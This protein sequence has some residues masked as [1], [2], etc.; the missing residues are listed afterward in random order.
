MGTPPPISAIQPGSRDVDRLTLLR[1]E[2]GE[3]VFESVR[4]ARP[5]LLLVP[6]LLILSLLPWW[7][8]ASATP[9]R[10]IVSGA[11]ALLALLA[12][13]NGAPRRRRLLLR[14]TAGELLAGASRF[15]LG[16]APRWILSAQS[17]LSSPSSIYSAELELSSGERRILLKHSDPARL[18][19]QL[20]EALRCWPIPVQC[21][22][23][24]P[25]EAEPWRYESSAASTTPPREIG[26]SVVKNGAANAGLEWALVIMATLVVIDLIFL[27]SSEGALVAD[28]HPF[29]VALPLFAGGAIGLLAVGV[30]TLERRWVIGGEI[31]AQSRAFAR[32]RVHYAAPVTSI[33]GVF[34]VG[35]RDAEHCHVLVD[36]GTGPL[37]LEVTQA[38]ASDFLERTRAGIQAA[39]ARLAG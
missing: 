19:R 12:A 17:E 36:S 3:L 13:G 14:P 33:R 21:N 2:A 32:S 10:V 30:T 7:G 6:M 39:V 16:P 18:L 27:V 11:L 35:A 34:T 8:Q 20:A 38:E 5:V 23:G 37:A 15:Q 24:L 9:S 1:A 31:S 29:S 26:V 28:V 22:W 25:P 4:R